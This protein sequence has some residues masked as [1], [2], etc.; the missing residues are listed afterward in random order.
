[1]KHTQVFVFGLL[2]MFV[3]GTG[4]VAAQDTPL[5]NECEPGGSLY[6][7]ENQ[8]GCPT[9]WHWKA[10]WFL[11]AVNDGD[12]PREAMP[13]EFAS[14]LPPEPEEFTPVLPPEP[15]ELPLLVEPEIGTCWSP[16]DGGIGLQYLGPL[17]TLGNLTNYMERG[18]IS[19][20][21]GMYLNALILAYSQP[22]AAEICAS[23]GEVVFIE[24][25][26]KWVEHAPSYSYF[27]HIMKTS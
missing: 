21:G 27:C 18:C 11:A 14:V 22:E 24:P 19:H 2:L 7:E 12:I 4:L 25:F 9:E 10:G 8:D 15:E 3:L 6:R 5:R 13:E 16:S 23:L 20:V 17:N 1:M 26:S